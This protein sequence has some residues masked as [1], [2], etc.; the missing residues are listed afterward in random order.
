MLDEFV[1]LIAQTCANVVDQRHLRPNLVDTVTH[2]RDFFFCKQTRTHQVSQAAVAD[3]AC[4]HQRTALAEQELGG[5]QGFGGTAR[6]IFLH[7][8][9]GMAI[10]AARGVGLV[11]GQL[12]TG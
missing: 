6:I 7:Q 12:N 1:E 10:H 2:Q 8:A 5:R 9:E 3:I 4:E 11:Q